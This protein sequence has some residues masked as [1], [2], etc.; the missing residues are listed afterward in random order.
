MI[1][2]MLDAPCA[3]LLPVVRIIYRLVKIFQWGIPIALILYGTIDLGKAVM[4]G[5]DKQV[6]EAQGIFIKRLIYGVAVFFVV[7]AVQAVFGLLGSRTTA[8]SNCFKCAAHTGGA[9][10]C[11]RNTYGEEN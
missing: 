2:E 5:D 8:N 9:D 10:G 1:V 6:K 3:G 7:L 4:A 11:V